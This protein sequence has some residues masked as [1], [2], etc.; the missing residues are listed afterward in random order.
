[1]KTVIFFFIVLFA[2]L[3]TG[4]QQVLSSGGKS[5]TVSGVTLSWTIGEPVIETYT[6]GQHIVT[7][8]FHQTKLV[9]TALNE[10]ELSSDDVIVYPNPAH[11]SV[12]VKMNYTGAGKIVAFYDANGK[13]LWQNICKTNEVKVEMSGYPAATY[14]IKI[15]SKENKSSQT[16]KILKR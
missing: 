15:L 7:Q 13:K 8:G 10:L 4:A 5:S 16:F 2:G 14:F 1:M 12:T 3:T 6:S 11:E 9:I